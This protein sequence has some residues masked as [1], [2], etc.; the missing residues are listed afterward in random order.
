MGPNVN[1]RCLIQVA[2]DLK[3]DNAKV[4]STLEEGGS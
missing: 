3:I 2:E 1:R 4:I